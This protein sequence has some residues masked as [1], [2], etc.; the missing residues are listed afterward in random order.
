MPW[1]DKNECVG[2]GVCVEECPVDAISLVNEKAEINMDEC[3][4]CGNCHEVCPEEAVKHDSERI[5]EEVQANV[6][7][8]EG[9]MRHF[10]DETEKQACLKRSMNFF[11]FQKTVAEKTLQ[12]LERLKKG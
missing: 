6:E 2:C 10:R 1:V 11:K 3:I 7:K 5:P 12:Q 8:V 9:Y 4:R